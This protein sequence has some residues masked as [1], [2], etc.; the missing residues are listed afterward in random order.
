MP[1]KS[2]NDIKSRIELYAGRPVTLENIDTWLAALITEVG[3]LKSTVAEL[4]VSL[5]QKENRIQELEASKLNLSP[6]NQ[7]FS[8]AAIANANPNEKQSPVEIAV[9]A[10]V[11]KEKTRSQQ[12]ERNV[13]IHGVAKSGTDQDADRDDIT[14]VDEI[15]NVLQ[16]KRA[17]VKRQARLKRKDSAVSSHD[18]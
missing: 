16:I 15:L 9:L 18:L 13:I 6:D 17:D 1:P 12:I 8:Y 10:A 14:K 3:L 5:T 7:F 4:K 2:A 11:R